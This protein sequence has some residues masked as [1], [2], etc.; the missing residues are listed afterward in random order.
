MTAMTVVSDVVAVPPLA[1]AAPAFLPEVVLLLVAGAAIAYLSYRL[2]LVPI[3]GFLVAGVL[4]GP[5]GLSLVQDREL[6]DAV[7]ELGVILLLFT[8][9]IELSFEKLAE[10]RTLILGGG[11][12][13]VGLATGVT[14]GLLAALG[15][16]WRAGLFTGFLVALS[17]TAIVLKL[18]ADRGETSTDHGRVS[19]GLLIFQDLAIVVMVL[20]VPLLAGA[21][22]GTAE[23]AGAMVWT[24]GKAVGLVAVL[25]L[26]ARR[27]VGWLLE[28]IQATCSQEIFVLTVVALCLGTAWVTSL[29]GISLSLGAFLAGL[30]VSESKWSGHALG[31]ILPLR[32]LFSATFFLSVGMLLDLGFLVR[33][34]PLVLTV[35]AAVL[36]IKLVT[37]AG[38]VLALGYGLST[39]TASALVLAQVGEFSFVLERAGREVGLHPAG[40]AALG[41]QT[42]IAT[43]VLLMAAT[44]LLAAGGVRL[45]GR[46]DRR[47]RRK[48]A[49]RMTAETPETTPA[50]L[51][52]L[53][54]HVIVAGYGRAA[55]RLVP[56]LE[57][58]GVP[59]VLTTLSPEG[60]EEA[61]SM[62]RPVLRGDAGRGGTLRVAGVRR[63]RA[64]V[65]ADDEPAVAHHIVSVARM[66]NTEMRIVVRTRFL[67]DVEELRRAGADRVV[68]EELEAIV[69]LFAEVLHEYD[70]APQEIERHEE[71]L[72]RGDYAA[73]QGTGTRAPDSRPAGPGSGE[74]RPGRIDTERSV[75][76]APSVS[77]EACSH[78]DGIRT[79]LP[80][81]PGCEECLRDGGRWVHLR[82]C[83]TCGHVG[84][85]D[86]SPG[87]HAT[88][89]AHR[90]GHPVVRSLEP[91]ETWGW[92]YVDEVML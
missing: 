40:S 34:W 78:L 8:I 92:C 49:E 20:A 32:V 45:G 29:A 52:D 43:T 28:R 42:L 10:I 69:G 23:G 39:A 35:A 88:A 90:T 81:A 60:A 57:A 58:A 63:A 24:L 14:V 47:R 59:Y 1:G 55:R 31:E 27:L 70:I 50:A 13:Q 79:V 76:L 87:R 6:V 36:G 2:G 37:T 75:S 65:V 68:A 64:L 84:C 67:A 38:G 74:T 9:G 41:P 5:H 54:D 15:V 48:G 82:I 7:A 80:S 66:L 4:L 3:V 12:L 51:R 89:H 30:L 33:H 53:S 61:E 91:G 18:L 56:V 86:E 25:L 19:L 83:M 77:A 17:S 46:L 85:C 22:E 44:P 62:G 72:R 21:G 73:I 16:D 11:G 26:V 71:S